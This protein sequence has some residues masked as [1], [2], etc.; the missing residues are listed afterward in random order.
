MIPVIDLSSWDF[1][2]DGTISLSGE[3]Q[4]YWHQLL[5]PEDFA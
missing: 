2:K 5:T 3:W 4:F 1:K